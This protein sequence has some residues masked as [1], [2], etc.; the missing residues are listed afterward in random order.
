MINLQQTL[1]VVGSKQEYY[2]A[3]IRN[4]Y[5]VPDFKSRLCTIQLVPQGGKIRLSVCSQVER[6]KTVSMPFAAK[7]RN[8]L[9][10]TNQVD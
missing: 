9:F 5:R 8:H 7:E 4:G 2:G 6:C 10:G 3:C 1:S